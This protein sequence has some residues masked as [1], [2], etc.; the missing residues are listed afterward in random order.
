MEPIL[1]EISDHEHDRHWIVKEFFNSIYSQGLFA[2]AMVSM[3]KGHSY[4]VNEEYCLFPDAELRFLISC[5]FALL[6]NIPEKSLP[7]YCKLSK[8]EIITFSER[9]RYIA[10]SYG[11][12]M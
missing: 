6:Q 8:Q 3:L 5:G 2:D 9:M 1:F 10:D 4:V 7:T 11:I 12:D